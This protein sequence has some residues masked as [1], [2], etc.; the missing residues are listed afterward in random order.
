MEVAAGLRAALLTHLLF[1]FSVVS[2][3]SGILC[4]LLLFFLCSCGKGERADRYVESD[5]L[6]DLS[7]RLRYSDL[8]E[9][10]RLAEQAL[11]LAGTNGELRT[12]ALNNMGFCAFMRMDFERASRLYRQ[13]LSERGSQIEHLIADVGMMKICQRTS[14]N[15]LFYDYRYSAQRRI[16]RIREDERQITNAHARA[17]LDYAVSEYHIVSGIYFYYLQQHEASIASIDSIKEETLRKDTAQWLYYEYMRG[18]GGMFHADSYEKTVEG[19]FGYLVDCLMLSREKGYI[20]FEANALQAMAEILNFPKNRTILETDSHGALRLAN[21]SGLPVDSLPLYYADKALELFKRYGDWYQISGTYR[22]IATY[23]NFS[24]QP[25]KALSNMKEALRY[26][27]LH[28]EIYYH[29]NDT[30]DRL[31]AYVQNSSRP[32]ELK[33]IADEGIKTVPEWILRLREQLSRTYAAMGCRQESDY[34]RNI[35]LDL[36]DYTRQDKALESRYALLQRE[37]GQMNLLLSLVTGSFIVLMLS[38]VVLNRR[39][40]KKNRLYMR[41]LESVLVLCRKI[42]AAIPVQAAD[43]DEVVENVLSAVKEDFSE[44]FGVKD[45]RIVLPGD[46]ETSLD[47]WNERMPLTLPGTD[48]TVGELWL[49]SEAELGKDGRGL[50][51]LVLPYLA[52]TLENGLNLVSM[53]EERRQLEKE[54]Y[55]H[56]QHL[57]DNKRRNIVKKACVSVVTGILP[58]IDR[59]ANEVTKLMSAPYAVSREV[60]AGKMAYI[61]EL[62]TR[63]NEYNDILALWIKVRRGALSLNVENFPLAE[64]FDMV[65]KGKRAFQMKHQTF[66]VGETDAVIKADKALT[67][68]MINTLTE[69]ARKYTQEGGHVSLMAEEGEDYVEISVADD[70]PGLSETDV[71]RILNEKVYDSGSIGIDTASDAADLRRKKGFGFGL[72]NCKGII[73]KY[74]KTNKLFSVC[75]FDIHSRPGEGSRFSFRLPKGIG[76]TLVGITMLIV[77]AHVATGCARHQA[78]SRETQETIAPYDSLLAIANN[79]SN[80]VYE[81]NVKGNYPG[82]LAYADSVLLYMNRHYLRYSDSRTPL[83]E[84]RPESTETAEQQWLAKGFDTDYYILLDVRNEVAVAALALNDFLLYYYNNQAYTALYKQISRDRSLEAYCARMQQSSNNKAIALTLFVL[85]VLAS[86]I[87]Y[88]TLYV[89]RLRRYRYAV[90]QVFSINRALFSSTARMSDADGTDMGKTLVGSLYPELNELLPITDM[91][92]GIYNEETSALTYSSLNEENARIDDDSELSLRMRRCLETEHDICQTDGDWSF[93]F[94]SV[95]TGGGIHPVGVL[96]VREEQWRDREDD[97]LLMELAMGYLSVVVYNVVIR[98]RRKQSDIELAR[99]EARRAW[100]EE[101]VLHVQN[102]VLDNCLSA[103]KHET[104]YYPNRIK[105]LIDTLGR[106]DGTLTVGEEKERLDE[107]NELVGYY[108]DIFTVLTSCAL[109]QLGEKTFRRTDIPV[110]ELLEDAVRYFRKLS[111]RLDFQLELET[112]ETA[113]LVAVGDRVLLVFL[114]ENLMNEAARFKKAG[115]LRIECRETEGFVRW[116]F[117]DTRRTLSQEELNGLFY[118]SLSLMSDSREN[119]DAGTEFLLCKQIIREHDE[120]AGRR[121]CRINATVC[122]QG[123]YSV[124]FTV[125]MKRI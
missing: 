100:Y 65:S 59:I 91:V 34:N 47:G 107:I 74:R 1:M 111:H 120:N 33:W 20:Y 35:Y 79:Y 8:S 80:L 18:S 6:S 36:L 81:C 14:E 9:S 69:N 38:F 94:L 52:W 88:Y 106:A 122:P 63:I 121:G 19:E 17:R 12:E 13:A 75:R 54:R 83:L 89:R 84:L 96:A 16:R 112:P 15:K 92:L 56:L 10:E 77:S 2:G 62:V 118:P 49:S 93:F 39:W 22:T 51:R 32:T 119:S 43:T 124:W 55:V 76:K 97:R 60:K 27:N 31:Y 114:L 104:V 105:T 21:D 110:A 3:Y 53:E 11:T 87:A 48:E 57:S 67:L 41:R 64:L 90:E 116:D 72:M 5:S 117:I 123:G 95:R 108:K 45:V 68:F 125:P 28:H 70:G 4:G 46:G 29:C 78:A 98:V 58:Y 50:L 85:I 7:Y 24:G 71:D 42:I 66:S 115:T 73:E 25:E 109:R 44:V 61:G 23:Y 30:T 102:M 40:R 103:I 86:L 82:A 101:N 99:D 113:D 37:A 26:V